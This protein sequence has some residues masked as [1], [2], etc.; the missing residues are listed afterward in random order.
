V[1]ASKASNHQ[2]SAAKLWAINNQPVQHLPHY[3]FRD[4]LRNVTNYRIVRLIDDSYRFVAGDGQVDEWEAS[5]WLNSRAFPLVAPSIP[6]Q[7]HRIC[8]ARRRNTA[9]QTLHRCRPNCRWAWFTICGGSGHGRPANPSIEGGGGRF[10]SILA[11]V[12]VRL[13]PRAGLTLNS[14]NCAW[15]IVISMRSFNGLV[16]NPPLVMQISDTRLVPKVTLFN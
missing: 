10:T 4:G 7:S 12:D 2:R 1:E 5:K 14:S 3:L 6:R 9:S 13:K 8:G 15:V 16:C 11:T